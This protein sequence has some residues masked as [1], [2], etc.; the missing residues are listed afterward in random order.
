[1][2][3]LAPLVA[4]AG[5][6]TLPYRDPGFP[7]RLLN[8]HA[9]RPASWHP[10][11]PV[12]FV[13][14][15]V[16]RNGRDYRDYWLPHVDPGGLLA[17]AIEFPQTSFPDHLWYNFGNLRSAEGSAE[18]AIGLDFRHCQPPVR[19]FARSGDHENAPLRPVRSLRRRPVRAP[20]AV[21]RLSRPGRGGGGRKRRHVCNARPVDRLA[22]GPGR[23]GSGRGGSGGAAA[24]PADNHGRHRG[25]QDHRSTLSRRA[26]IA[27]ARPDAARPRPQLPS[28]RWT[29]GGLARRRAGLAGD[30]RAGRGS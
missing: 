2:T 1:M 28:R 24:I 14:H 23:H 25:H 5:P 22:L 17:I 9:A 15:G 29:G 20:D 30:R 10:G 12:L 3:D 11:L 27:P 4:T 6:A 21:V 13:H 18:S 7:D 8:L 19:R 26:E 16:N